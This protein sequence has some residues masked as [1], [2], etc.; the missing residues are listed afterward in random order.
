[1]SSTRAIRQCSSTRGERPCVAD[2]SAGVPGRT[3]VARTVCIPTPAVAAPRRRR[4]GLSGPCP[5]GA[6]PPPKAL[7]RLQ[8]PCSSPAIRPDP[9]VAYYV[10][11]LPLTSY[12][13]S[14]S[15]AQRARSIGTR[16]IRVSR[17]RE[18]RA[19]RSLAD[20]G[21][22]SREPST[23]RESADNATIPTSERRYRKFHDR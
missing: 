8:V 19:S 17:A 18:R 14:S 12:A 7:R 15:R 2:A 4:G 20:P 23:F 3:S 1:M 16:V 13:L 22:L 21:P 5:N 10:R 6:R 11:T 9:S